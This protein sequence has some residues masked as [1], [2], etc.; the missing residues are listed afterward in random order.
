MKARGP[1]KRTEEQRQNRRDRT[2]R[3][4]DSLRGDVSDVMIEALLKARP[5]LGSLDPTV[6]QGLAYVIYISGTK[7]RRHSERAGWFSLNS[8]ELEGRFGRAEFSKLNE[9]FGLFDVHEPYGAQVTRAY[10]VRSHVREVVDAHRDV[11][12][13]TPGALATKPPPIAGLIRTAED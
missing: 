5:A 9:R 8:T 11:F 3:L 4:R 1:I 7:A 2:T 10:R 13:R 6:V 12:L